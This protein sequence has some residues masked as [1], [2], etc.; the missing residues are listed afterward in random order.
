VADLRISELPVLLP[1]DAEATDDL[2][3]ADYSSSETRRLSLKGVVQRGI[4]FVDDGAIPGAK[5][6]ADSVTSTQLAANSVTAVELADNAVDTEAI[7]ALAVTNAKLATGIDGTKLLADSVGSTQIAANAITA[8]ELADGAVDTAA[9]VDTAITNVKLA[10]GIDGAKLLDASVDNAKLAAGISGAKLTAGS[11]G[12]TQIAAGAITNTLLATDIDGGKLAADS[13]TA[14][15]LAAN[16]VGASELADNA[17]DTAAIAA[18]AVTN[19]KLAA[20]IDG[21]KLVSGSVTTVQIAADAITATELADGAVDTAAVA[22]GAITDAKLATGIDGAKLA[23]GSVPLSKLAAGIVDRGLDITNGAIGHTNALTAGSR[24]GISYDA[25]GHI[26]GTAAI[27]AADLPTATTTAAGVVSISPTGGLSVSGVGA[28]SHSN[29]VVAGT[30]NGITYDA[31]GHIKSTAALVAADLP[32][33]TAAA[34][35]AASFPGPVLSID[36]NG[37]VTHSTSG[38]IAGVHTKVTVNATGHVTAGG[39][40]VAADIP[41]LDAGK[42]TSGTLDSALI[43]NRSITQEKLADYAVSFIQEAVPSQANTVHNGML[44]LQESTGAVRMWNGNSWFPI[45]TGRLTAENLRY[46]GVF[47]AATGVITGVTQF[48]TAEGFKVNDAIPVASDAA[49]GAYFVCT[50]PGAGTAQAASTTF[51]AGDW[52]LCN[53]AAAGW[54]RVDTLNGASGGGGGGGA[55]NLDDLLDVVLTAP[56]ADEV[57]ALGGSG[58]WVNKSLPALL[59]SATTAVAGIVR[60]ADASAITAGTAGRV[61]SADQLLAATFWSSDGSTIT[62]KAAGSSLSIGTGRLLLGS[63][64]PIGDA[65]NPTTGVCKLQVIGSSGSLGT[66]R[67]DSTAFPNVFLFS[68]ARGTA[69]EAL[70]VDDNIGAIEWHG[71]NGTGFSLAGNI[72]CEVDGTPTASSVPARLVFASATSGNA[73]PVDRLKITSTGV[74]QMLNGAYL[75]GYLKQD[76]STLPLLP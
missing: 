24:N 31:N 17:V 3:V 67:N 68:K 22:A 59:P 64:T 32:L 72:R 12:T 60:L 75:E 43:G 19:A 41:S 4:A 33:A 65:H 66:H 14:R 51:D 6:T 35:G 62:P 61:V 71:A 49:A 39:S 45:G 63:A 18:L 42:L 25:Q 48:G 16:S 36:G 10:T 30:R 28:V 9:V 1:A 8:V 76:I 70:Q 47:N 40:L 69:R 74:I 52:I 21:A 44:W 20:G 53:G 15:E 46:C 5:L 57:L 2:A 11:V 56:A 29:T 23:A 26:T 27:Q 34:A 50:T 54:V 37:A 73:S 55:S 38:V 13:I 7:A 58:Q